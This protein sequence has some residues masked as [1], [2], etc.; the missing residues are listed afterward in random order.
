[1]KV[2][3]WL[4]YVTAP[5][6]STVHS[7]SGI[8]VS[9]FKGDALAFQ[10]HIPELTAP[11]MAKP[12]LA[13]FVTTIPTSMPHWTPF[14]MAPSPISSRRPGKP[15]T[16]WSPSTLIFVVVR[17]GGV[18]TQ[19]AAASDAVAAS[20]PIAETRPVTPTEQRAFTLV[21]IAQLE[22]AKDSLAAKLPTHPTRMA[23]FTWHAN[24]DS[25]SRGGGHTLIIA[26]M[27]SPSPTADTKAS[28]TLNAQKAVRA[29]VRRSCFLPAL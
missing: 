13:I 3:T 27:S 23:P 14:P 16:V 25:P 26:L 19:V 7:A 12:M 5:P 21:V 1:M 18:G 28:R 17:L 6:M 4:M 10:P 2:T 8:P 9:L 29:F 22:A 11:L 24:S 20:S 15:R